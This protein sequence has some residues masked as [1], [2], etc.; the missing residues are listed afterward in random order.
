MF[1]NN[2]SR[3][4]INRMGL[5]VCDKTGVVLSP[6]K[7]ENEM[8]YVPVFWNYYLEGSYDELLEDVVFFK[9]NYDDIS[10]F[11]EL[12]GFEKFIL[13]VSEQG[14]VSGRIV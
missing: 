6:G 4:I 5:N 12:K 7:F 3:K 14:F 1:L 2:H 13:T 11:P 9:L 8:Y 10:N